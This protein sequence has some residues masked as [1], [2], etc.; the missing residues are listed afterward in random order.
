MVN[1]REQDNPVLL[2]SISMPSGAGSEADSRCIS[3]AVVTLAAGVALKECW[4]RMPQ[5]VCLREY[6]VASLNNQSRKAR[7]LDSVT[8]GSRYTT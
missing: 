1:A 6:V 4:P 2:K 8:H 5:R 3:F 7:S